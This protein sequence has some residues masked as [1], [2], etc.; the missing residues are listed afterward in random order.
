MLLKLCLLQ[1]WQYDGPACVGSQSLQTLRGAQVH[2][3]AQY[4]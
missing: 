2:P 3:H 4:C 1:L